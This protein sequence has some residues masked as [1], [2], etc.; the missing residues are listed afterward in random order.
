[1]ETHNKDDLL[2]YGVIGM[3]WGI[4]RGSVSK[5]YYKSSQ[6]ADSLKKEATETNLKAAKLQSKALKKENSAISERQYKKARKLKFKANKKS[7][8]AAKLQKK[9]DKW[10]KSMEKN[11]KK[12]KKSDIS[13]EHLEAGKKYVYMLSD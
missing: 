2:H 11:F 7:L 1:M 13:K 12:T 10:V 4:R 5:A 6:K 3:K 8:E 9:G